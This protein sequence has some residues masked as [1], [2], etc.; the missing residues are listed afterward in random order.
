ITASMLNRKNLAYIFEQFIKNSKRIKRVVES[1]DGFVFLFK[2][3]GKWWFDRKGY[4]TI[5]ESNIL[6][7]MSE[8]NASYDN[9]TSS[10]KK[11][12]QPNPFDNIPP[13]HYK[14]RIETQDEKL[15][16]GKIEI[17]PDK[18]QIINKELSELTINDFVKFFKN[19]FVSSKL[20]KFFNVLKDDEIIS[21]FSTILEDITDYYYYI[22][23]E[24]LNEY[25]PREKVLEFVKQKV[26]YLFAVLFE[27]Y[28]KDRKLKK[29]L[30]DALVFLGVFKSQ[31][32]V[33]SLIAGI[34]KGVEE[35][36]ETNT[37]DVS[38][39]ASF[40]NEANQPSTET[41]PSEGTGTQQENLGLGGQTGLGGQQGTAT[42][43]GTTTPTTQ[44]KGTKESLLSLSKLVNN[45]KIYK[46][47]QKLVSPTMDKMLFRYVLR[48]IENL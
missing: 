2:G 19:I 33:Q 31:S 26:R 44:Q 34:E 48:N 8:L 24:N 14:F 29:K 37:S 3:G 32:M 5:S 17:D 40:S 38:E 15:L 35:E 23:N 12:N 27:L 41:Q 43:I 1:S 18:A 9:K 21:I 7:R 36:V 4:L 10:T 16:S 39:F 22:V 47:T 25:V 46:L 13:L 6:D 30:I 11:T 45:P 28:V 42:Q 20:L